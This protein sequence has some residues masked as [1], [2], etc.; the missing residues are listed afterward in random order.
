[1]KLI[2]RFALAIFFIVL[3]PVS[4]FANVAVVPAAPDINAKSY[5]LLDFASNKLLVENNVNEKLP[6][7]SLTKIMTVY[8]VSKELKQGTIKQD[9]LVLVSEKAW[10]MPGSRM[11]I[12]V[13]KQ[14]SVRDLLKGVIIQSGND[15]S[16]ALAEYISGTEEAFAQLMNKHAENLG[17]VNTHYVNSTGL[18]DEDHYSTAY[19]LALLSKALISEFP[20]IYRMHSIK[21]FT[22]NDIKQSNR[23]QL[24][25]LDPSVDGLKTGHTEE[26]GYCLVASALRDEMRLISVVM[27]TKSD[28]ARSKAT[29]SLLNFGFRFYETKEIYKKDQVIDNV[30]VWKGKAEQVP[31][32]IAESLIVTFPRGQLDKM[33]ATVSTNDKLIA[34]ISSGQNLGTLTL[35]LNGEKQISA[36]LVAIESVEQA[37][38]LN[39][40]KDSIYL[41]ME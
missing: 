15:A 17:M 11:F 40:L 24:L 27:G 33:K 32:G 34:P 1:M 35:E 38:F 26:A 16:V 2:T 21:Q 8:V 5:V 10:R 31:V 9:D 7:A 25:W 36:P 3:I 23:N 18:P 12:E 19:D 37:G 4:G 20:D 13:N 6:P 22:Y 30:K 41:M 29:Q 28:D 39:R 14:V